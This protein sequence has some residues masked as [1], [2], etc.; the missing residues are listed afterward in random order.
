MEYILQTLRS[1]SIGKNSY[2]VD[3][4]LTRNELKYELR[5]EISVRFTDFSKCQEISNFLVE[6]LD[7]SV[8]V[9]RPS[10]HYVPGKVESLRYFVVGASS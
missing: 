6:K 8:E 3:R 5:V 1:H 4:A 10:F 7:N 9:I 2:T